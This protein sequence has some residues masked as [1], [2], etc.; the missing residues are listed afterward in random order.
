[1]DRIAN[2]D[3]PVGAISVHGIVG[4][5]GLIAVV[6]SNPEAQ[7]LAQLKGIALIF[8]WTFGMSLITWKIIKMTMGIRLSELEEYEGAD[9]S[10]IGLEAYPE[11]TQKL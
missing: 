6:F 11:F 9:I 4:I 8:A 5:W 7:I 1:M 3:D 2:I 10:E